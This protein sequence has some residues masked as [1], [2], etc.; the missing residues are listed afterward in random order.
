MAVMS[1]REGLEFGTDLR[2][3]CAALNG[4]VAD[5]IVVDGTYTS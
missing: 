1:V 3:D 2:S 5:M 4:L